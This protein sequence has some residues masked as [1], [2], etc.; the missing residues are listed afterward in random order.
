MHKCQFL[1]H[2]AL[3]TTFFTALDMRMNIDELQKRFKNKFSDIIISFAERIAQLIVFITSI[4]CP[5]AREN[6]VFFNKSPK[7]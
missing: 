3:R 6:L 2:V 5:K 4:V 1:Y 7:L